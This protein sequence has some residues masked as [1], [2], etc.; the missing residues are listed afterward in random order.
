M[1]N[2]KGIFYFPTYEAARVYAD[3]RGYPSDRIIKYDLGWA[4]QLRVSGPYVGISETDGRIT[5]WPN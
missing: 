4:I 3:Y 2:H 1:R 5:Q